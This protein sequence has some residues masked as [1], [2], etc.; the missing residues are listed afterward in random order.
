MDL[1]ATLNAGVPVFSVASIIFALI[2]GRRAERIGGALV[3]TAVLSTWAAQAV[4]AKVPL[5]AF[6]TIDAGLAVGLAVLTFRYPDKLWPGLAGCAQFLVLIFSVTRLIEFPLSPTAFLAA[7]NLSSLAVHACLAVG[8][9]R[10]RWSKPRPDEW[11]VAARDFG[12]A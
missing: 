5:A 12:L 3:G 10:A 8:T 4:V 1:A 2:C 9:W 6:M 11:D 7:L